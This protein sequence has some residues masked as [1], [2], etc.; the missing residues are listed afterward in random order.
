MTELVNQLVAKYGGR[1]INRSVIDSIIKDIKNYKEPTKDETEP[2][3]N[4]DNILTKINSM[5]DGRGDDLTDKTK[6]N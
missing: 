4:I 5:K 2:N 1:T 6:T 3:L